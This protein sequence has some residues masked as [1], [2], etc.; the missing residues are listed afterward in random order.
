MHIPV[1]TVLA[2]AL[3]LPTFAAPLPNNDELVFEKRVTKAA[4]KPVKKPTLPLPKPAPVAKAKSAPVAK[5]A[6][7]AAKPV[8]PAK[9]PAAKVAAPVAAKPAAPAKAAAPPV[10]AAAPPA[11]PAKAAA[12]PAKAAPP[13]AKAAAPVKSAA[14]PAK[15]AAPPAKASAAPAKPVAAAKSSKAPVAKPSASAKPSAISSTSASCA[16]ARSVAREEPFV[17]IGLG[18]RLTQFIQRTVLGRVPVREFIGWHGTNSKTAAFWQQQGAVLKP[19]ATTSKFDFLGLLGLTGAGSGSSGADAELGPGLY[20]TDDMTTALFF[21]RNNEAANKGTTAQICAIFAVDETA[22]RQSP[23][24]TIP[25]SLR[26]DSKDCDVAQKAEAAR[27]DYIAIVG[28]GVAAGTETR[29]G[30]LDLAHVPAH[31][32]QLLI[33]PPTARNF[34][35][36]CFPADSNF[37]P[38]VAPPALPAGATFPAPVYSSPQITALWNIVAPNNIKATV[39]RAKAG[40]PALKNREL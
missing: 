21:A 20:V 32:N 22:W 31:T 27:Q 33:Q 25:E 10:K 11:A 7:V 4:P 18:K 8:V 9:A 40:L 3:A 36:E 28:A 16:V 29:F 2:L 13:P 19:P 23:K 26:Q 5:P 24:F 39:A 6:P 1:A 15:V 35:A 38:L 37:N 34:Q 17:G 12:P 30:P 14:P